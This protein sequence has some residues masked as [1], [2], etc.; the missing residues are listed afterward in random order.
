LLLT[1]NVTG[2]DWDQLQGKGG[3]Y[4]DPWHEKEKTTEEEV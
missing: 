4:Q 2:R 1:I 3:L